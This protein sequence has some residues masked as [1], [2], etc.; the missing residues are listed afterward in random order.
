MSNT[1]IT[2]DDTDVQRMLD[3]SLADV[4]GAIP[5]ILEAGGRVIEAEAKINAP[6][7]TGFLR[8]S[9]MVA[10]MMVD[11]KGGYIVVAVFAEYGAFVEFGTVKMDAQPYLRPAVY[12][13]EAKIARAMGAVYKMAIEG[14]I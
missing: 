7:D 3:K 1:G 5:Q 10:E 4:R 11:T 6:V 12:D 9:I 2:L 8:N 13:N 14:A